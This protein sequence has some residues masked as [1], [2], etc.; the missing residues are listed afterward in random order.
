MQEAK[1]F[2]GGFVY[3]IILKEEVYFWDLSLKKICYITAQLI[4]IK[5]K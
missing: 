1:G 5:E 4:H 2:L 3:K